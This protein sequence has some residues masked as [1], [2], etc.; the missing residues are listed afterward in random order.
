MFREIKYHKNHFFEFYEKQTEKVKD[1]IDYV[2]ELIE[3]VERVPQNFLK[4]MEGTDG[5]YEI[6]VQSGNNI[7]RVFC[8]FDAGKLI[9]LMNGFQ[10]KTDKTP[11]KEIEKAE[12]LREEYFEEKKI[13]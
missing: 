2:L 3:K 7:F 13:I 6:R 5:L 12:L 8:F 11:K 10:K 1:K 9:V 4:H